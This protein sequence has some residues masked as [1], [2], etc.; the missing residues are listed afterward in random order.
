M[1]GSFSA[2]FFYRINNGILSI[3]YQQDLI[4]PEALEKRLAVMKAIIACWIKP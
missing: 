2:G 3:V 4:T 1:A